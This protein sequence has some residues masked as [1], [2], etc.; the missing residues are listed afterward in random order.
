M[1]AKLLK[2]LLLAVILFP[3]CRT[4][5]KPNAVNAPM[6]KEKGEAKIYGGN[7]NVQA[8]YAITDHVGVMLNGYYE[9]GRV[10]NDNAQY[11]KTQ[12][13]LG[14]AG[15]GYFTAM[16]NNMV[17]EVYGGGGAGAVNIEEQKRDAADDLITERFSANAYKVF[18]QPTYGYVGKYFE[19]GLTPR[20]S[21][22]KYGNLSNTNY[23]LQERQDY[24]YYQLDQPTWVF[25]EPALT[26][27]GGYKWIKLQVQV[28]HS[29]KLNRADLNYDGNLFNA[30]VV[31]DI[32]KWYK[33]SK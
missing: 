24:T 32:A 25:F 14:E 19:A 31:V 12:G 21:F 7:N 27:R 3:S 26:L 1:K 4:L 5:Y 16:P 13:F 29:F 28:G 15:A 33:E 22:V 23:T 17:F 10:N 8:A 9:N 2:L 6:L 20:F 11:V 18:I 30:G